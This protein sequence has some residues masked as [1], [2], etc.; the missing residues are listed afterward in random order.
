MVIIELINRNDITYLLSH[1]KA[2]FIIGCPDPIHN[3]G[4]IDIITIPHHLG[5]FCKASHIYDDVIRV[6]VLYQGV[7]LH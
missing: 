4:P 5:P 2:K 7:I 6:E 3:K 1:I